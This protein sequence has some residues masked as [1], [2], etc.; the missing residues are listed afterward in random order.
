M[1]NA[2]NPATKDAIMAMLA[3]EIIG[4]LKTIGLKDVDDFC[5]ET[6]EIF[7][8]SARV[9]YVDGIHP[10]KQIVIALHSIGMDFEYGITYKGDAPS[11]EEKVIKRDKIES[12]RYNISDGTEPTLTDGS[13][14]TYD[15]M[16]KTIKEEI[17]NLRK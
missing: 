5:M 13:R 14:S 4:H 9:I 7:Q 15:A 10:K 2:D 12:M 11:G 3:G 17:E 1:R 16:W 8:C 6:K